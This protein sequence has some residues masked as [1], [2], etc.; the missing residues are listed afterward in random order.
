MTFSQKT[1]LW[2]VRAGLRLADSDQQISQIDA[3]RNFSVQFLTLSPSLALSR[4]LNDNAL[5]K[6]NY[7]RRVQRPQADWLNPYTEFLTRE[8]FRQEIRIFVRSLRIKQKWHI[9][10][11]KNP[12]D[13]DRLFLWIIPTMRLPG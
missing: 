12:A 7:S 11:M 13:G 5:L 9:P 8:I 3:N 6:L 10:I 4:K 2:G 1:D